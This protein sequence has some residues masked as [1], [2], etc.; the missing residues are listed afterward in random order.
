MNT[1]HLK[2]TG[3]TKENIK[4]TDKFNLYVNLLGPFET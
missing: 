2:Q 1:F 4:M 3:L